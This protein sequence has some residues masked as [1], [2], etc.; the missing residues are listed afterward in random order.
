MNV[1]LISALTS[2]RLL[3][4]DWLM[5]LPAGPTLPRSLPDLFDLQPLGAFTHLTL[6]GHSSLSFVDVDRHQLL[7]VQLENISSLESIVLDCNVVTE[8]KLRG[9]SAHPV[10]VLLQDLLSTVGSR[11]PALRKLSLRATPQTTLLSEDHVSYCEYLKRSSPRIFPPTRRL[12]GTDE[13]YIYRA[14][15]VTAK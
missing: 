3:S 8:L 4:I 7:E 1:H 15:N 2:L 6:R 5:A 14:N 11:P 13:I 12:I 9:Q 10:G